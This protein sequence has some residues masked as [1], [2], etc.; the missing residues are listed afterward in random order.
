MTRI[1]Q[2]SL[3]VVIFLLSSV[4]LAQAALNKETL[5][6]IKAMEVVVENLEQDIEKDGL[7]TSTI[8]T[9]VEQK[10]RMAGIKVLTEEEWIKE[11]GS[12]YL[13]VGVSSYKRDTGL[14]AFHIEVELSQEVILYRK[15]DVLCP[16]ITWACV[17]LTGT[18]G[19][20]KVNGLRDRIKDKID[21]FIND[22]FDMNPKEQ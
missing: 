22:Y 4:T 7:S 20:K 5:R 14:Y 18:V 8:Q 1:K 3:L 21:L 13:Y 10:L 15:P 11:P 6:G 17:G 2:F 12:P 9:D 19:A 16:A